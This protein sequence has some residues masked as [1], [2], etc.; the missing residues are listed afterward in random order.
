MYTGFLPLEKEAR[1]D[2]ELTIPMNTRVEFIVSASLRFM[3][4]KESAT[5]LPET[6]NVNFHQT[7]SI[8]LWYK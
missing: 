1:M 7:D 6:N 5:R 8:K 3:Y 4:T 2:P